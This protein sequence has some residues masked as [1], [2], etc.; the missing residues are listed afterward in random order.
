[1]SSKLSE[2][3]GSLH[4][5]ENLQTETR[6]FLI[7]TMNENIVHISGQLSD[8][9]HILRDIRQLGSNTYDLLN[10]NTDAVVAAFRT[11]PIPIR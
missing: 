10:F 7:S 6:D 3:V 4:S 5:L 8:S 9:E 11:I 1:M 2:M